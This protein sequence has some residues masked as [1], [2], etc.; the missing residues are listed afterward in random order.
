MCVS[1]NSAFEKYCFR[2]Q[3]Y[4]SGNFS[5]LDADGQLDTVYK[6]MGR[7]LS[8]VA[9]RFRREFGY[10]GRMTLWWRQRL[11]LCHLSALSYVKSC[12]LRCKKSWSG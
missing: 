3:T 4:L 7:D 8:V 1:F 9:F 5:L 2:E 11:D 10:G 12:I 6:K